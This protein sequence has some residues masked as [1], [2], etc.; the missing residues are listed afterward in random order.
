MTRL[1][2]PT[3]TRILTTYLVPVVAVG[4]VLLAKLFAFP[5]IGSG[6][7]TLLFLAAVIVSAWFG[8]LFAG[9]LATLLAVLATAYFFTVPSRTIELGSRDFILLFI[10]FIE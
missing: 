10:F 5:T 4:F 9:M 8:G 3:L 6:S 1:L 2:S 7:P